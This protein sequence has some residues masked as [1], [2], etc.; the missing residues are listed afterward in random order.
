MSHN[1]SGDPNG[2]GDA[3][4]AGALALPQGMDVIKDLLLDL[5]RQFRQDL[6]VVA[7]RVDQLQLDMQSGPAQGGQRTPLP[8]AVF[9]GQVGSVLTASIANPPLISTVPG[10]PSQTAGVATVQGSAPLPAHQPAAPSIAL[11]QVSGSMLRPPY[12]Q[13]VPSGPGQTPSM[14]GVGTAA[15]ALGTP[16]VGGVTTQAI[17][18]PLMAAQYTLPYGA[19]HTGSAIGAGPNDRGRGRAAR[20]RDRRQSDYRDWEDSGDSSGQETGEEGD[21]YDG[22]RRRS[23]RPGS[24]SKSLYMDKFSST[25]K[26]QDFSVWVRQFED[27]IN[28]SFNLHSRR[29]HHEY[30]LQWLPSLLHTEAYAI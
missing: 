30:C 11:S 22:N 5:Q 15:N 10:T 21:G 4:G 13:G 29:R 7:R 28:R 27:A 19:G 14:P 6:E 26:E 16:A 18:Q 24:S 12:L 25:N 20:M 8:G 23:E 9:Q 2:A 1:A 3:S 17:Q